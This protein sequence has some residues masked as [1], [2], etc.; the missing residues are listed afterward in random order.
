MN[1]EN[2]K[3]NEPHKSLLNLPQRLDLRSS[4]KHVAL[5]YLLHLEKYNKNITITI[6]PT[7]S[8]E[9]KFPVGSNLVSH[10]K[11]YIKYVNKRRTIAH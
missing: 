11:D 9:F 1:I 2:C 6:A 5:V 4:N 3:A 10:I 8:Y 7:R